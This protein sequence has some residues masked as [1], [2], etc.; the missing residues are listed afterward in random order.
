MSTKVG[1]FDSGSGGLTVLASLRQTMPHHDYLYVED[2]GFAPYGS[3]STS[4]ITD[5]CVKITDYLCQQGVTALVVAC[6]TATVTAIHILRERFAHMSFV[7]IEPAVKP[8]YDITRNGKVAVLATPIT[9][10]SPRLQQLIELWGAGKE[11]SLFPSASLAQLIDQ[12]S[13]MLELQQ[14][15]DRIAE[16]VKQSQADVLVLACTHYPHVKDSLQQRLPEVNIIEPSLGVAKRL[17]S[18]LPIRQ[19][20]DTRLMGSVSYFT[21]GK[22]RQLGRYPCAPREIDI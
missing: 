6:N 13:A 4:V 11:T 7:G 21:T 22:M 3:H 5:R 10:G 2:A 12:P 19:H 1:I 8:A 18:I 9:I 15:L 16:Q 14:E 17:S 20:V